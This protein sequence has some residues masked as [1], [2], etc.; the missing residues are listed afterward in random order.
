MIM[1]KEQIEQILKEEGYPIFMIEKTVAKIENF[2]PLVKSAFE[3]W[4]QTKEFENIA[5]ENPFPIILLNPIPIST[6]IAVI[7]SIINSIKILIFRFTF[8]FIYYIIN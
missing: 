2:C 3:K 7:I 5:V 8:F 6:V 4:T 1:E